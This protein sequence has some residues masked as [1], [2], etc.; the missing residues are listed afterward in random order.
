MF[1]DKN[2]LMEHF[3]EE[4]FSVLLERSITYHRQKNL[5]SMLTEFQ[6]QW[7]SSNA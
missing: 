1:K 5:H 2:L 6:Q 7:V 3:P 4:A